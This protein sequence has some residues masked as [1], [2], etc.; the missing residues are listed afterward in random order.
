MKQMWETDFLPLLVLTC[1]GA[2]PV[3][4]STGNHFPGFQENPREFRKII[5]STGC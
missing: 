3:K 4:I 1:R 2:A 5:T